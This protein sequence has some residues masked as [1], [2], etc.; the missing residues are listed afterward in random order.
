[1]NWDASILT[2]RKEFLN[3]KGSGVSDRTANFA[4]GGQPGLWDLENRSHVDEP[5]QT[6]LLAFQLERRR[7]DRGIGDGFVHRPQPVRGT[8]HRNDRRLGPKL[9]AIDNVFN[10]VRGEIPI[11]AGGDAFA[12]EFVD[13]GDVVDSGYF[14]KSLWNPL[15]FSA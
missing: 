7:N 6:H 8:D 5:I 2:F 10:L 9:V 11:A 15:R 3:R 13:G 4:G 14:K 1:M 12:G